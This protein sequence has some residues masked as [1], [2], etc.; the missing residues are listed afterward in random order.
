[1]KYHP[2]A[3]YYLPE[4]SR[5]PIIGSLA[6]F[7]LALSVANFV[8]GNVIAHYFFFA[9][10][11]LLVY[12]MFGWFSLVINESMHG[13]H[14]EQ[15]DRTYRWGMAWFIVS[16]LAFFTL[17]FGALFYARNFAVPVLGGKIPPFST[18][19]LLWPQFKAAW[20]LI[21]NPNPQLFPGPK[22]VIAAFGIPAINTFILLTSAAFVTWAHWG[23]KVNRRWQ[24]N[25]GLIITIMLGMTF[26][27]MQAFEYTEAY[28]TFDLTLHSGIYGT[29]F[30]MLTGF[31]AAHVTLGLTMLIV[32]LI[33]CLKGH[34]QPEHHF[35]F[36]AVSW[37][38]HFVD[39][40]W[41]FLFIFVYWL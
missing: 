32:I 30:F 36:E 41:L 22:E 8:H 4:P 21:H 34:F 40:V 2:V 24:V 5:W 12:M 26:L 13:L 25:A 19:Q 31:H 17:F 28:T 1:M 27:G 20:P 10:S 37:Y 6:L 7:L 35:A 16:E 33:R 9:G 23:L 38:W 14:S 18:H 11:L 3:Y 29:T 39:V 15:M